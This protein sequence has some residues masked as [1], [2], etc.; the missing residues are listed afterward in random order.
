MDAEFLAEVCMVSAQFPL[1]S[2]V[3]VSAVTSNHEW[4][5]DVASA[6]RVVSK[7]AI[8]WHDFPCVGLILSAYIGAE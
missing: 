6:R 1:L 2:H 4:A 5:Q 8:G 7:S 3:I